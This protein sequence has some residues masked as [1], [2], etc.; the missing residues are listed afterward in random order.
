M[1]WPE[2]VVREPGKIS[3][4]LPIVMVES[5]PNVIT[6]FFP[7]SK[8]QV[9]EEPIKT[10]VAGARN[11]AQSETGVS[12]AGSLKVS[13]SCEKSCISSADISRA[14]I[15]ELVVDV[16]LALL[17][18]EVVELEMAVMDTSST[19]GSRNSKPLMLKPASMLMF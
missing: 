7:S 2:R 9:A 11:S 17:V 4:L 18:E 12:V 5:I 15:V 10:I 6:K 1:S 8:L 3:T 16:K 14:N 13:S 19:T